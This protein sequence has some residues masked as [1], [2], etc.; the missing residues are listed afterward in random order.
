MMREHA[1]AA[2]TSSFAAIMCQ[3]ENT[4]SPNRSSATLRTN[5][6]STFRKSCVSISGTCKSC[7]VGMAVSAA[8]SPSTC[9]HINMAHQMLCC[10]DKSACAY[11]REE[12]MRCQGHAI[13]DA[14]SQIRNAG[15]PVSCMQ[16]L[17]SKIYWPA[18]FHMSM[19]PL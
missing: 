1:K 6:A 15:L 14:C 13:T 16:L 4:P 3:H 10:N 8:A 11:N 19:L 9:S 5:A 2:S 18:W 12:C 7:S 17:M